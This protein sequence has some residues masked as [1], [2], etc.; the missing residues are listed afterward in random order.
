VL[1]DIWIKS[2]K[3]TRG[4]GRLAVMKWI[5]VFGLFLMLGLPRPTSAQQSYK[6]AEVAS[7]G[8][9]YTDYQV[10]FD[11]L[12]VLDVSINDDGG[13][14][15]IDALRDP[16]SML[17]AAKTSLRSW[18]FHAASRDGKPESSRVTVSFVYRP[19]DYGPAAAVPPKDFSPVIPPEA[20]DDREHDGYVPV[21]ILSFA[22]P[23][24]PVNSLASG[25]VVAQVTVDESGVM[26]NVDFLHEMANF[27]GLVS[28]ALKKWRFQPATFKGKP[29]TSKTVVAFVFQTPSSS[30]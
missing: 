13:V 12:F 22:Y 29:I 23:D 16:G 2:A 18:K 9:A 5:S 20:P 10:V 15:R 11:G 25:S 4:R 27:N 6:P 7:A 17:D 8:D 28:G 26:K 24:Y 3:V 30:N 14:H 21:S 19:P 1:S